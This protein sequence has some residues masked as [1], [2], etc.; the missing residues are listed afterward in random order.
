[1]F[2]AAEL[3]CGQFWRFSM[4]AGATETEKK[5]ENLFET[6]MPIMLRYWK[7]EFQRQLKEAKKYKHTYVILRLETCLLPRPH[8]LFFQ[9]KPL[10]CTM[11]DIETHPLIREWVSELQ[12]AGFHKA[13]VSVN[14]WKGK[15]QV[16]MFSSETVPYEYH[17]LDL[18]CPL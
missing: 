5:S 16:D 10:Y 11:A 13:K 2:E 14:L 6:Y 18:Y 17:A 1:L 4:L 12:A 8:W 9:G 15:N 7:N 3:F